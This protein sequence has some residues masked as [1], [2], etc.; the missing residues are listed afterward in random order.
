MCITKTITDVLD[1]TAKIAKSPTIQAVSDL[2]KL[3]TTSEGVL[4]PKETTNMKHTI[5]SSLTHLREKIKGLGGGNI[6]IPEVTKLTRNAEF[7]NIPDV[8]KSVIEILNTVI[9]GTKEIISTT[10]SLINMLIGEDVRG[11]GYFLTT[12]SQQIIKSNSPQDLQIAKKSIAKELSSLRSIEND[13]NKWKDKIKLSILYT[14]FDKA[15]FEK[16]QENGENKIEFNKKTIIEKNIEYLKSHLQIG[17]ILYLNEPNHKKSLGKNFIVHAAKGAMVDAKNSQDFTSIHAA[18]YV[19]NNKIRHIQRG[20]DGEISEKE[21]SIQEFFTESK[22]NNTLYTSVAIGRMKLSEPVQNLFT[23]TVIDKSNK[24][25]GYSETGAMNAVAHGLVN[26]ET[27]INTNSNNIIC[28]D[29]PRVSAKLI[30]ENLDENNTIKIDK[31]NNTI[32]TKDEEVS[33]ENSDRSSRTD[34]EKREA[35]HKYTRIE[36]SNSDINELKKLVNSNGTFQ[37]FAKFQSPIAM[38]V[39]DFTIEEKTKEYKESEEE[40]NKVKNGTVSEITQNLK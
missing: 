16:E 26:S 19:G 13:T 27:D 6:K 14:A 28:T 35:T 30:L 38:N 5:H 29:L 31:I 12:E 39:K 21:L 8:M 24:V 20:N 25:T 9:P 15:I 7:I 36:L 2:A 32:V 4:K 33:L 11:L 18:V 37:M 23:N 17:D 1:S 3:F 10:N 40:K 34:R 22:N